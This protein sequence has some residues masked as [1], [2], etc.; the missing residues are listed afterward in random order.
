VLTWCYATITQYLT[1]P[2]HIP[3]NDVLNHR[4]KC[5]YLPYL[6]THVPPNDVLN[7]RIKCTYLPYLFTHIPPNDVLNHWGKCTYLPCLFPH[8]PPN[9]VLNH[10]GKCTYLPCL[11]TGFGRYWR[12]QASPDVT[13]SWIQHHRFSNSVL[14]WVCTV[15]LSFWSTLLFSTPFFR[16]L[17]WI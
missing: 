3:P 5:T 7:H 16:G 6:F 4:G 15:A 1:H 11:F 13:E 14:F 9:D 2:S 12:R 8:V 10:R 17:S